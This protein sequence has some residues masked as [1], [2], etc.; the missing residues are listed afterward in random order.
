MLNHK[1]RNTCWFAIL[2]IVSCQLTGCH[3]RN[4]ENTFYTVSKTVD[5]WRFPLIQPFEL[6]SPTNSG[7]WFLNLTLDSNHLSNDFFYQGS[8]YQLSDIESVGIKDSSI[9]IHC[10]NLYWPKLSGQYN[11][12]V[13]IHCPTRQV[14]IFSKNHHAPA[15]NQL[16]LKYKMR[17]IKLY[18]LEKII[19]EFQATG[20]LPAEWPE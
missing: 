19:K 6:V 13:F 16:L 2:I 1:I 12:M 18:P 7:D 9:V 14:S 20:K 11:S 8:D 17:D 10:N 5:L 4:K 3:N 15:I